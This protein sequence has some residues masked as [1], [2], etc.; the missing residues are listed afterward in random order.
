MGILNRKR[1]WTPRQQIEY[2]EA[3]RHFNKLEERKQ[4]RESIARLDERPTTNRKEIQ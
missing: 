1:E 2:E 3:I 4:L